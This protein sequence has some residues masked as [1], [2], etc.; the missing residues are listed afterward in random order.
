[1]VHGLDANKRQKRHGPK[2]PWGTS[3]VRMGGRPALSPAVAKK[4][5][6]VKNLTNQPKRQSH[7]GSLEV[8][9]NPSIA[10]RPCIVPNTLIWPQIAPNSASPQPFRMSR[11]FSRSIFVRAKA[12]IR[13]DPAQVLTT[14]SGRK[15][16]QNEANLKQIKHFLSEKYAIPDDMA[17]QVL[18]HKS[19]A[20]G[21]KPYNEKLSV[22]GSKLLNLFSAKHVVGDNCTSEQAINGK[23]MDVLG[24]PMAKELGGRMAL[25]VFAKNHK[26][27][28][29]M[30][31]K[32]YNHLLSFAESGELKVSAQMMYALVG[33]VTFIHGKKRAEDFVMEKLLAVE[34]GIEALA[35]Q[36][37]ELV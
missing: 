8:L 18:T 23:N 2:A 27:N 24:S 28:E 19:F 26:L 21:I 33:A 35:A 32:S 11:V 7:H 1:M 37:I 34:N 15:Y 13:K 20:N 6:K 3:G 9:A 4:T 16:E 29:V 25:G 30:F 12:G 22:M 31:W 36:H 10:P 14:F 17:L 5:E